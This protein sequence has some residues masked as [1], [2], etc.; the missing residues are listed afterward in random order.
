MSE[1]SSRRKECFDTCLLLSL[2]APPLS[3]FVLAQGR[4]SGVRGQEGQVPC[5]GQDPNIWLQGRHV[6]CPGISCGLP[7]YGQYIT[8]TLQTDLSC[9]F[10]PCLFIITIA[11]SHRLFIHLY[12]V[13]QTATLSS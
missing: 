7:S 10:L 8:T 1:C 6:S 5:F 12:K 11:K 4:D 13:F 9:T 2:T 3:F